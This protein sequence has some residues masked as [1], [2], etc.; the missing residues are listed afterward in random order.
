MNVARTRRLLFVVASLVAV[1]V[2][3]MA[4]ASIVVIYP[5]NVSVSEVAPPVKFQAGS[6]A[7][8]TG[9]GGTMTVIIGKNQTSAT[10]SF[11]VTYQTNYIHDLLEIVNTAGNDYYVAIRVD[12]PLASSTGVVSSAQLI[13]DLGNDNTTD[14]TL[15]LTT[16]NETSTEI[17]LPAGQVIALHF[18]VTLTEGTKLDSAPLTVQLSLLYSPQSGGTSYAPSS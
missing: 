3:T 8:Q 16:T 12:T 6:N 17:Q 5:L 11:Q 18:Q 13:L 7:N 10:V 14:G 15:D 1:L 2:A 9:L 4:Y